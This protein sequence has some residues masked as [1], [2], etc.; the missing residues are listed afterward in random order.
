[1][2]AGKEKGTLYLQLEKGEVHREGERFGEVGTHLDHWQPLRWVNL[3]QEAHR[4]AISGCLGAQK[5]VQSRA[6]L[7]SHH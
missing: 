7:G 5:P 3:W 2:H 1:M 4:C 6:D